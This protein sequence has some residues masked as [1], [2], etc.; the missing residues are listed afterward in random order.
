[1]DLPDAG[2][3]PP[4]QK[5]CNVWRTGLESASNHS[6]GGRLRDREVAISVQLTA[7]DCADVI[8]AKVDICPEGRETED[9][10]DDGAIVVISESSQCDG[11]G[12]QEVESVTFSCNHFDCL[13]G[14]VCGAN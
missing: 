8:S 12:H 4:R 14:R 9:T 1:M 11:E 13:I 3:R 7:D 6:Q 2:Q 5:H 10:A